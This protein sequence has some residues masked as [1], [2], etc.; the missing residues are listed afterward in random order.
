MASQIDP[1]WLAP[2]PPATARALHAALYTEEKAA[3]AE[4]K[5][6]FAQS[7]QLLAHAGELT[8]VGDHVVDAI[9]GVPVVLVRGEDGTLRGF[10]NVCRHRAGPVATCNG[11]GARALRCK[12]HGWTYRLDGRLRSAPEM[13]D[14]EAF[15]VA[16]VRLPAVAV[17]EWRGLV[18]AA[19]GGAPPLEEVLDGMDERIGERGM[20]SWRF[21]RRVGYEIACNWKTYVDNFLEGYHLPHI[22]PELNRLLDYRSYRTET[23]RW[24][25]L[26]WSPLESEQGP[27][28][29]G[30]ALYYFVW[31]NTM[32]NILPGRLQT[33]RVI[34]LATGRCRVDFD[35]Y[36]PDGTPAARREQDIAFSDAVQREDIAICEAV[37][38]RLASGSYGA[39][40]LN[41][42]REAGVHHFHELVRRALRE[43]R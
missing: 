40:R 8:G 10:H 6:I 38:T 41:P 29:A 20:A 7:W 4:R 3:Y 1:E 28:G 35:Y 2:Q 36:Y 11:R 22:H 31:P 39:G 21:E 25:S 19:L 34:P 12:Y 30:D 5:C 18:F 23:A 24:H 32:L 15:D 43:A 9:G 26:Q 17:G 14:A 27:Y 16:D 42:K 37:Q 13:D 33:N